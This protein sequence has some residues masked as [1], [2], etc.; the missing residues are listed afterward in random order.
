VVIGYAYNKLNL[1]CGII[2]Y[3][4]IKYL[5]FLADI[6]RNNIKGLRV[7]K[8]Y[9]YRWRWPVWNMVG[10]LK[11]NIAYT[12]VKPLKRGFY[13][14]NI[15]RPNYRTYFF[16]DFYIWSPPAWNIYNIYYFYSLFT[17]CKLENW[18]LLFFNDYNIEEL[19]YKIIE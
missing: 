10:I 17:H 15:E 8:K 19:I 4:N 13:L 1:W 7:K 3:Y 9:L 2:I 14:D 11:Q 18:V 12:S 16:L 6:N 5:V